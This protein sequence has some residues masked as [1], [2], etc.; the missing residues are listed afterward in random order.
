M[1]RDKGDSEDQDAGTENTLREDLDELMDHSAL[2]GYQSDG[3]VMR[4]LGY[5]AVR[6]AGAGSEEGY[7]NVK[8]EQY[9]YTLDPEGIDRAFLGGE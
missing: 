2:G 6:N 7:E 3:G 4:A 1:L 8:F 5:V 9:A